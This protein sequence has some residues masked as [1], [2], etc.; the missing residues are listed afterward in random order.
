MTLPLATFSNLSH[1]EYMLSFFL[2]GTTIL[3]GIVAIFLSV[4]EE[5]TKKELKARESLQ[6]RRL[7]E[8]S[9]LKA[10]QDRIG[11][12]LD[13]EKVIDTLT[14]SLKNLFPYSTASSLLIKPDKLVFKTTID[15]AIS[16][17]F[18]EQVKKS[19]TASLSTILGQQLPLHM[20]EV[21]TGIVVDETNTKAMASFFNIPLVVSGQ[22]VGLITVASTKPGLYLEEDMTM[23]YQ[24]TTQAASALTRLKEVISYEEGKL[25]AM[26]T[27]LTDGILMVDTHF[28]VSIIN[29]AAKEFLNIPHIENPAIFDIISPLSKK[30]DFGAKIKDAMEKNKIITE[31]ELQLL[32]KIV[33]IVITPVISTTN[34]QSQVIGATI[35]IHDITLEK[36][37]SQLKEDFTNTVVHELRSPLTAIKSAAELM[38]FAQNLEDSQK[39]LVT[40]IDEQSKRMLSDITSLLDAAKLESGHFTVWQAPHDIQKII[41]EVVALFSAEAQKKQIALLTDIQPGLPAG[42]VD[43]M[44]IAQVVNNLVSN[45]LKFTSPGGRITILGKMQHNDYLPRTIV[46]PGIVISVSDNGIGIPKEK[47][48]MLFNKFSQLTPDTHTPVGHEGTGLGLYVSKGIVEAHG[49]TIF[50]DSTPGKG[51]TISFTLPIAQGVGMHFIPVPISQSV[52]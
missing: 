34:A 36:T 9:T 25:V 20:E 38:A 46:N 4:K 19:M 37:L 32:D 1:T 28:T 44:R 6:K 33:Q 52:N 21:R 29:K 42:Y 45:S 50:L 10:I 27:S 11:Y 5:R 16:S 26:I 49:G 12:S 7:Y 48:G 15:E 41:A 8:V 14:G 13:I 3:F 30:Y 47:Q 31:P 22:I 51:T 43:P 39:K 35:L 24:M 2:F 17:K 40:I 23:L 18:I